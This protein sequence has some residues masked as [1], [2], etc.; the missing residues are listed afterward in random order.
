MENLHDG[1]GWHL[2]HNTYARGLPPS[3]RLAAQCIM[4]KPGILVVTV[5][6]ILWYASDTESHR[7]EFDSGMQNSNGYGYCNKIQ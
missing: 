4:G 3:I 5:C 1:D 7:S 2:A 6:Y